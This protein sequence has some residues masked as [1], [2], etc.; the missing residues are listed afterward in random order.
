VSAFPTISLL[1]LV[2]VLVACQSGQ[3]GFG[4]RKCKEAGHERGT[5]AFK[6]CVDRVY[7]TER[8]MTNQYRDGGP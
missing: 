5:P 4:E 2:S 8:A 7:A 1:A 3:G 6:Q